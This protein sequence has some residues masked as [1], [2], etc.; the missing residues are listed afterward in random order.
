VPE[1]TALDIGPATTEGA[2]ALGSRF[3]LHIAGE[4]V[5]IYLPL[6]GLYNIENFLA[7]AACGWALGLT[8][9][10]IAGAAAGLQGAAGR[11]EVHRVTVGE[12]AVTVIDDS[13]NSNPDAAERALESAAFLPLTDHEGRRWA[14]LGD[15]L[16]LGPEAPA[17]HRRV[18][19][20]AV[21]RG[22]SP[23]VGVGKL[24]QEVTAA[25]AA[26]AAE[27]GEKA[28]THAFA[29]AQEAAAWLPSRLR[30]GD[31]VLIKGSRGVGLDAVVRALLENSAGKGDVS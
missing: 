23:V 8:V 18:A 17:L 31:L 27:C 22:F 29:T 15:M 26:A 1:V 16:E 28:E 14:V 12:A 2:E 30:S 25:A 11:G 5:P 19:A 3:T 7:A 24:A 9:E 6:H 21:R 20:T 4:G 10:E 13:Y